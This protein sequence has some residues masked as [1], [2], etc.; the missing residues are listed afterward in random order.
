[1]NKL[2][3][4]ILLLILLNLFFSS[5]GENDEIGVY[6]RVDFEYL[7]G[8]W[9]DKGSY[10]LRF[11][12]FYSE[13]QA[14]FG[15]YGKNFEEYDSFNYRIVDTNQ[16]VIDFIND[17]EDRETYHD[18]IVV[19]EKTMEI[20]DLT[21]I[22]ENPNKIYLKRD[23]ITERK[24]DTILVG[25]HQIYFDFE[26]DFRLQMD[27]VVNDS[28]CPIGTNCVWEGNAEIKLD[29]ILNGNYHYEFILNTH[30]DFQNDTI[31]NN[32]KYEVIGLMPYPSNNQVI[33]QKEYIVKVLTEKQ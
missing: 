32:I 5:C 7:K 1:M 18:L 3:T 13:N 20:S 25:Y 21:I 10:G 26:N 24:N 2:A 12:D 28:R 8:T 11:L 27:S 19:D 23:I 17:N 6:D 29:L 14:R 33:D 4:L 30:P 9:V 16:L 15:S 31:I 22:P